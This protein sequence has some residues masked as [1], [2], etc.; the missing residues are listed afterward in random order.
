MSKKSKSRRTG[1]GKRQTSS[2]GGHRRLSIGERA[3][4]SANQAL[5]HARGELFQVWSCLNL[6]MSKLFARRRDCHS[7]RL[8]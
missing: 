4:A 7:R 1:F 3:L 8:P 2:G 5:A 6:S